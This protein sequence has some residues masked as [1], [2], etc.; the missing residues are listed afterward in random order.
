MT[1]VILLAVGFTLYVL[2]DYAAATSSEIGVNFGLAAGLGLGLIVGA[3]GL[4]FGVVAM[5]SGS[6]RRHR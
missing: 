2:C 4:V 6:Q 3:V 1:S 5:L